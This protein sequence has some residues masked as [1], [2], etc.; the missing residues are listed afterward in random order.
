MFSSSELKIL[1][2]IGKGSD[3]A[4]SLIER[5]DLA[6]SQVYKILNSLRKDEVLHRKRGKVILENK[7]HITLLVS[8]LH[9]SYE[10]EALSNHGLDILAELTVSRSVKE[11]SQSLDIHQTT[12]NE[13]VREMMS[14]GMIDKR[15]VKYSLNAE[16]WPELK[17]LAISYSLYRKY[18]RPA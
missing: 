18:N 17:D 13:K 16:Q 5:T 11:L 1:S 4:P 10:C 7:T 14:A 8:V 12:V 3:T 15:G 6:R 9:T 2:F